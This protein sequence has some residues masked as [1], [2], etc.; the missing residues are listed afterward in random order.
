MLPSDVYTLTLIDKFLS[1]VEEQTLLAHIEANI[2]TG[3][4]RRH[5]RTRNVIQRWGS[6]VP[7]PN[8]ILSDTIPEHFQFVLDRLVAQNLVEQRPDSITLNQY[9]KKQV[10]KPHV[11]L[12]EGGAVITVL[13]LLTPATMVFT[14]QKRAFSVELPP[15]SLVQLRD[16][17]RY[18][19]N[20]EI[21]PVADTRYSLV[22][23][24]SREC[25]PKQ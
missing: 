3:Y 9:L 23:R 7:Y 20:H 15:R 17:I 6:P 1:P 4:T 14:L 16:E 18:N 22:F 21:L 11:D 13:S 24:C 10:I 12:P 19:W 8:D 5:A 25:A 2:P